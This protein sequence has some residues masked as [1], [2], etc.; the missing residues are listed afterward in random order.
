MVEKSELLRVSAFADLPEDQ[1]AWFISQA[2]ELHFKT[3][4]AYTRQ[5]D[6]A[7]AM[8]VILEGQIE[9]RGEIGGEMVA[10]TID[11]GNV[12]GFR[13]LSRRCPNWPNASSA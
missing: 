2:K 11:A 1:L 9:I 5:G 10:F 6:P 4:E 7:D 13:S 8:F 3:G 12:T